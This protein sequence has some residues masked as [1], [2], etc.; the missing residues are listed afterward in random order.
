[1]TQEKSNKMQPMFSVIW[2]VSYVQLSVLGKTPKK[3]E[4]NV[5]ECTL[6]IVWL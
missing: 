1:M 6:V 5:V 4:K 3:T 2:L